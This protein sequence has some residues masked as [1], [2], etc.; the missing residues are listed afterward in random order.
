[1]AHYTFLIEKV[2]SVERMLANAAY[3]AELDVTTMG[4][5][6]AFHSARGHGLHMLATNTA[7]FTRRLLKTEHGV[8]ASI[9]LLF[10]IHAPFAEDAKD[11]LLI[12]VN[13]ILIEHEGN[14][15]LFTK[16]GDTVLW[17]EDKTLYLNT[18]DDIWDDDREEFIDPP[19][20]ISEL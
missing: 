4:K 14:A 20:E 12:A 9:R 3:A 11:C 13:Q 7:P 19:Y 16:Q 8:E 6:P 10:G 2:K 17:R 15:L 18:N 1:M 5:S